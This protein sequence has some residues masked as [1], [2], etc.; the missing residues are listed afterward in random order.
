MLNSK[1]IIVLLSF[2]LVSNIGHGQNDKWQFS[3]SLQ[4]GQSASYLQF[5]PATD[6]VVDTFYYD[7]GVPRAGYYVIY[8]SA[9]YNNFTLPS[10]DFG[11]T[12]FFGPAR[13]GVFYNRFDE[14]PNIGFTVGYDL[15]RLNW[16]HLSAN[17]GT[18]FFYQKT[19][20][21]RY[22][23]QQIQYNIDR[24]PSMY[25]NYEPN[26]YMESFSEDKKMTQRIA[27]VRAAF[28][29]NERNSIV[30]AFR[31]VFIKNT[32]Q[33]REPNR[34]I[35]QPSIS[36]A[37]RFGN[38]VKYRQPRERQERERVPD[39]VFTVSYYGGAGFNYNASPVTLRYREP[40]LYYQRHP[41][42][43]D[44]I[45][46][47]Y[48]SP[49]MFTFSPQIGVNLNSKYYL[50]YEFT[51]QS[52]NDTSA[53]DDKSD[54]DFTYLNYYKRS[55]HDI[56]AY[57]RLN[58]AQSDHAILLG[59]NYGVGKTHFETFYTYSSAD[60]TTTNLTPNNVEFLAHFQTLSAQVA[61]RFHRGRMNYE[62][63]IRQPLYTSVRAETWNQYE[64][65]QVTFPNMISV[66]ER[67][68]STTENNAQF[69]KHEYEI[70]TEVG[71]RV[72][73]DLVTR[74]KTQ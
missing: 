35:Y 52:Q 37:Y 3:W 46:S 36:Y 71:I 73:F 43:P 11:A 74:S 50:S 53:I 20:V 33:F 26:L 45:T 34:R 57:R 72:S 27:D 51:Y 21:H 58:S 23:T 28:Q 44:L 61:Y 49:N 70:L 22:A 64:Y 42:V 8:D 13:A 69:F 12:A 7:S 60:P 10:L 31:Y 59:L 18:G 15:V 32:G 55:R 25:E 66:E 41:I 9:T 39:S 65:T 54:Y 68:E 14:N 17:V 6:R 62:L 24:I 1:Y 40:E 19:P 2:L 16:L 67:T 30:A 47:A 4:L 48:Y 63:F 56:T 5:D 29:L 38:T